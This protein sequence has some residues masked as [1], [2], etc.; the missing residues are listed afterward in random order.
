MENVTFLEFSLKWT[1]KG[2]RD[3]I[4]S[5]TAAAT[6]LVAR[7][8]AKKGWLYRISSKT[9]VFLAVSMRSVDFMARFSPISN[10]KCHISRIEPEDGRNFSFFAVFESVVAIKMVQRGWLCRI[11]CETAVFL[12][13][14]VGNIGFVTLFPPD[15]EW[16]IVST[17]RDPVQDNAILHHTVSIQHFTKLNKTSLY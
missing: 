6:E 3:R 1:K 4:S 10:R 12:A 14:Q 11:P 8:R 17:G 15:V 5:K 9:A 7:R 2:W 16:R 13:L